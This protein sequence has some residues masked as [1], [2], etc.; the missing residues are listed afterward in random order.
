MVGAL[1]AGEALVLSLCCAGWLCR[2]IGA[3]AW[4]SEPFPRPGGTPARG[5]AAGG[6]GQHGSRATGGLAAAHAVA[7]D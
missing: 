7:H 2:R 3:A 1:F 6:S 5:A 4:I